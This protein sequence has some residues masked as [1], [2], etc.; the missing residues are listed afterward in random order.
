M[1]DDTEAPEPKK[2]RYYESLPEPEQVSYKR[3]YNAGYRA[4]Q[5]SA[6]GRRAAEVKPDRCG[7]VRRGKQCTRSAGWGT[8]HPG[9]GPCKF[10]MGCT[11]SVDRAA[12]RQMAWAELQAIA[13][14]DGPI[15]TTKDPGQ[16][17]L[18]ALERTARVL[19]WYDLRI[20][21]M[22]DEAELTQTV[23]EG[24]FSLG[25]K[26]PS[27]WVQL[28]AQ[29]RDRLARFAKMALDN[30]VAERQIEL[31]QEQGRLIAQA[32]RK[33][34]DDIGLSPDQEQQVPSVVRRHLLALPA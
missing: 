18:D 13:L 11:P 25:M 31:A 34:L 28:H 1:A 22:E 23:G 12:K 16:H 19:A 9:Y 2:T 20:A 17:L 26:V 7:V 33:I 10:H 8:E 3:G 15:D 6:E 29:E 5:R 27:V 14:L 24:E 32:I 21:A 4:G 30:G